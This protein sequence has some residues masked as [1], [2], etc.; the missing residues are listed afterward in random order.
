LAEEPMGTWSRD[1]DEDTLGV[2]H[3]EKIT[4]F[5]K[6]KLATATRP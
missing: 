2:R 1:G 4:G 5:R 3:G 6:D